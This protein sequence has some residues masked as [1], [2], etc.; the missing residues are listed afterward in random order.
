MI[1]R[2]SGVSE[3]GMMALT[4]CSTLNGFKVEANLRR[5]DAQIE[6]A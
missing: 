4:I 6:V 1:W 5:G 3:G 2:G